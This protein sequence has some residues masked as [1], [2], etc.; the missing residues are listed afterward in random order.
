[1]VWYTVASLQLQHLEEQLQGFLEVDKQTIPT[2]PSFV[3][4]VSVGLI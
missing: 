4:N 1:M 3:L 2:F